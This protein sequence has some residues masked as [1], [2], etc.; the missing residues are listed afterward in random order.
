MWV[1]LLKPRSSAREAGNLPEALYPK[2]GF[3]SLFY[4]LRHETW[5]SNRREAARSS[6]CHLQRL[7]SSF[8]PARSALTLPRLSFQRKIANAEEVRGHRG[9]SL[10][11]L[12]PNQPGE[13][14]R[15]HKASV[16]AQSMPRPKQGAHI[17][18]SWPETALLKRLK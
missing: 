10:L 6:R 9:T 5:P 12:T 1:M 3:Y 4:H 18:S 16:E 2:A 14:C 8:S 15:S 17:L 13:C 11:S 7:C